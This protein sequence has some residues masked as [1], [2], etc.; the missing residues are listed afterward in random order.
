MRQKLFEGNSRYSPIHSYPYTFSPPEFF[1]NTAQKGS[2]NKLFDTVRQKPFEGNSWYSPTPFIHKLFGYRKFDGTQHRRVPLRNF[3]ALWD[4]KIFD[5]SSWY[6][7]HS[8]LSISFWLPEIL[9]NTAQKGSSTKNFRHCGTKSF[10]RKYLIPPLLSLNFFAT[11]N[12][13]KHSTEGF[14]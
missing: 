14:A 8:F 12:F 4:K 3:L 2:P 11:R 7:L 10:R 1:W 5:G 6:Y 9:W 13:L